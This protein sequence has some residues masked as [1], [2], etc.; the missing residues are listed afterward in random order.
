MSPTFA[1]DTVSL[2]RGIQNNMRTLR[3]PSDEGVVSRHG[4]WFNQVLVQIRRHALVVSADE[5]VVL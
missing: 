1:I 3:E 2:W 5:G 4:I